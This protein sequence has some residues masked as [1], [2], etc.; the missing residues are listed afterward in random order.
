MPQDETPTERRFAMAAFFGPKASALLQYTPHCG[1]LGMEMVDAG[2]CFTTIRLPYKPELVGDPSRGVVFGGV[3]TTLI[4]HTAGLSVFCS[5]DEMRAIATLD[6][7]IDYLRAAEPGAD[8]IGHAECYKMTK[9]VA[10]VRAVAYDRDR[11]DPFASCVASFMLGAHASGSEMMTAVE[12][13]KKESDT[14]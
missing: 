3:I 9:N 1:Y 12:N 6:L 5:L 8:L 7:R 11:D 14:Q 2:P 10:F 13:R 4:D